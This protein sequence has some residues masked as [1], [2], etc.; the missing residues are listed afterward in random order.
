MKFINILRGSIT[1][2]RNVIF[3]MTEIVEEKIRVELKKM[4]YGVKMHDG[5]SRYGVHYLC[6]FTCYIIENQP[7][8]RLISLD[9]MAN[10]YLIKRLTLK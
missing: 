9:P 10:K 2:V 1:Q 6:Y 7:K 4:I 3:K 8:S 5:L